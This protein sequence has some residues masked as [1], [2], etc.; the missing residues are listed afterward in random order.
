MKRIYFIIALL[1]PLIL[2][3]Q[4]TIDWVQNTGGISIALDGNNNVYT[5]D[6]VYNP[7]GDIILTKRSATGNFIW[8]VSYDQTDNTRWE[9]LSWVETDQQGNVV[10][11]GT[12]MS[13]YSNPVE[14]ASIVMKF[15]PNG[16][17]L[18]RNVYEGTFDGSSTRKCLIDNA[19]N[20]YVLGMGS[21]PNGFVTKV[22]KF[23]PS[24]TALWSYFD[25]A[26]IGKGVNFKFT[27]DNHIV[28]AARG[29]T[30]SINGYAKIDLNG[31]QIWSLAGVNSL[32]VGDAAGDAFG[33]TYCVH[34]EYVSNGGTVIRKISPSG[35][36]IWSHTYPMS[37]F[38]IEVGSD[39]MPVISGFPNSGSGG[40]TF[41]KAD[42][43]GNQVWFV[44]DADGPNAFLLHAQM[45]ID[46]YNHVYLA[47]GT[48][49]EMGMCKVNSDGSPAWYKTI[50]GSYA[51]GFRVGSDYHVYVVGGTTARLI[52]G[53]SCAI[54]GGLAVSNLT[55]NSAAL[56]WSAVT[57]A[58]GYQVQYR[59]V[60]AA[61]WQ[62]S[63]SAT[64]TL[65]VTGL[66]PLTLYEFRV[67]TQCGAGVNSDWSQAL[68]FTTQA[69]PCAAP[70][71]NQLFADGI[72]TTSAWL[73][74]S[75]GGMIAYDWRYR[76]AGAQ[77]WID[78]PSTN[79]S[80]VQLTGL[81]HSTTYEFQVAVQCSVNWSDWSGVQTFNTD[82][83]PCITPTPAQLS[84]TNITSS[85]VRLNCS[86]TGVDQYDW[87]YRAAGAAGWTDLPAT[88][89]N[90]YNLNGLNQF[91]SYEFQ[92]AVLCQGVWTDWSAAKSFTT[93]GICQAPTLSQIFA[94]N[95]TSSAAR[96]N[97]SVSG[98]N[99]YDW[100]YRIQGSGTWTDLPTT[101]VNFTDI[102]GLEGLTAYEFQVAVLCGQVWSSWSVSQIFTT[103][104]IP[105]PVPD[106]SQL[107]V[108]NITTTTAILNCSL[109]GVNNYDWRYRVL[110]TTA[111]TD[112]PSTSVNAFALTGLTASTQYE[113]Q[114]A[115]QCGAIWT[116]W[117]ESKLFMTLD[118][119]CFAPGLS[120]LFVSNVMP[121]SARLNCSVTGVN[122]YD[123]RYKRNTDVDWTDLPT[124]T[125][126]FTDISG[127]TALSQ[128]QFQV[129][130]L[131]GNTWSM[132]S[133][134]LRFLTPGSSLAANEEN[135]SQLNDYE[136]I[137][138]V[139]V[140]PVPAENQ[141][142]L[143]Y[144][145]RDHSTLVLTII[146]GNGKVVYQENMG[147]LPAGEHNN[148][149][150]L[151]A[152][153]PGVYYLQVQTTQGIIRKRFLKM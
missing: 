77:N 22:K 35:A 122:A 58:L 97:S 145:L 105:C 41:L 101:T 130:V 24:G 40:S 61:T 86:M 129:A 37:G 100:R 104:S 5:V 107:L 128:Y 46:Q 131:C 114:V 25:N 32:T 82:T 87:R 79:S 44:P 146:D 123:W 18:W 63:S 93:D 20:I 84:V 11:V 144:N 126:N 142:N 83:P 21:G 17:L 3:A 9:R 153:V 74:C 95:V 139:V 116:A 4:V 54:P 64:T 69:L 106:V 53:I 71:A 34:G 29:I 42:T 57:G 81:T 28:I 150:N 31:N 52:Q 96:L 6:Y 151:Q 7:G 138:M 68:R 13:G 109:S 23:S 140:Y 136:E 112:L 89:L 152:Y 103:P 56:N 134:A 124:T 133:S 113:F 70:V 98:V 43:E 14:A 67:L 12:S 45:Y 36:L 78:L 49:F 141:L 149:I 33:N 75:L 117:S 94:T 50:P 108:T 111:W 51:N 1:I 72:T 66:S 99:A 110:G 27:P 135:G 137:A 48:L 76:V 73:N 30:G 132:W 102:S 55:A 92:V 2:P 143:S 8:E 127:L 19:N 119:G 10:V 59:P 147:L 38:R 26:G 60:G 39:N 62:S 91:T 15:D 120:Q 125:A 16:N 88:I 65:N 148:A 80:F 121:T 118:S 115:V 47:A 90:F 85:S